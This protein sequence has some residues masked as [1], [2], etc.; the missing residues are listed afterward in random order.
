VGDPEHSVHQLSTSAHTRRICRKIAVSLS[1]PLRGG[2][3]PIE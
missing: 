1:I 3:A 2:G